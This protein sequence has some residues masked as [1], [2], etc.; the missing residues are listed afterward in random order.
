MLPS[1]LE[2]RT[3]VKKTVSGGKRYKRCVNQGCAQVGF[4][5]GWCVWGN[6]SVLCV[7]SEYD[8]CQRSVLCLSVGE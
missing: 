7:T 4:T 1:S 3:L 2:K 8:L 5:A 6:L